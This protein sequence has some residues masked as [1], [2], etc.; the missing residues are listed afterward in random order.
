LIGSRLRAGG[1]ALLVVASM[2][3]GGLIT[4]QVFDDGEPSATT[5]AVTAAADETASPTQSVVQTA[6]DQAPSDA[7][8]VGFSTIENL[9]D[10]VESVI[11]SVV[12][13][14]LNGGA[15]TGTGVVLDT[16][17]HFVTNYHVV[18]SASEI[19]V[20]LRDGSAARAEVLG[21]DPSS[22]LAVIQADFDPAVLHPATFG[23]SESM[24]VGDSVFAIGNP[25][26]QEWTVTVGIISGIDRGTESG[27]TGRQI[28]GVIQTDAAVNPGNSGG[29]LFDAN[30][31][32]IGIN[33]SIEG[34][35]GFRGNVGLGFAVPSNTVLR[36][37]P[38]MLAGEAIV[39]TQ[40]GVG[41]T[42]GSV[43]GGSVNEVVAS[44]LGLAVDRGVLVGSA[45]GAA[46]AA[47]IQP[48]DVIT[49]IGGVEVLSFTDLAVEI[50]GYE[51]GDQV[52]IE[53][54]RNG[55]VLEVVA[56]LQA[57]TGQ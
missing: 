28:L 36:Y 11:D 37:L 48:G 7:S 51:V 40:L 19:V 46:Q 12:Y 31:D 29:P 17:G 30:G 8:V 22:D 26:T 41:V 56:T 2:L 5:P 25:F 4:V 54:N 18:E 53:L 24:R 38:A 16:D 35:P 3:V 47:G 10:V 45:G 15:G 42:G 57:W 9:P 14:E 39:H 13:I 50:D 6:D 49:K 21:V 43:N 55:D 32:V 52:T 27:F 44:D 34:P 20:R 23:D 1:L 33:T